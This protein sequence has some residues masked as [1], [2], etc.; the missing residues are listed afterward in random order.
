MRMIRSAAIRG[1]VVYRGGGPVAKGLLTVGEPAR[2]GV[3]VRVSTSS[4]TRCRGEIGAA[5]RLQALWVFSSDACGTYDL[6]HI[7]VTHAG[8]TDPRVRSRLRRI[9][10]T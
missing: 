4:G 9:R 5:A 6:P 7:N 3:L 10:E 2:N 8:R 1:E